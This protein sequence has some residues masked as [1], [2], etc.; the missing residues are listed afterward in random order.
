MKFDICMYRLILLITSN[1]IFS[2]LYIWTNLEGDHT[3]THRWFSFSFFCYVYGHILISKWTSKVCLC[4]WIFK[5]LN[6]TVKRKHRWRMLKSLLFSSL[7]PSLPIIN[8]RSST[9]IASC[10]FCFKKKNYEDRKATMVV[11]VVV[12]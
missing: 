5:R 6:V 8:D 4:E 12:I 11:V 3:H 7:V 1:F 9:Y 10:V 2:L